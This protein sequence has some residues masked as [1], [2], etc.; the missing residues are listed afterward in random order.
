LSSLFRY[1]RF[2]TF[3]QEIPLCLKIAARS[4]HNF[5]AQTSLAQFKYF[6]VI[7]QRAAWLRLEH[8]GMG[9]K[10]SLWLSTI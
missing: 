6:Q 1:V 3:I 5:I 2:L 9:S 4:T 10:A 8:S 7:L